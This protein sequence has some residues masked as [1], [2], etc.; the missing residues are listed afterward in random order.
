M[1]RVL[2]KFL[3]IW[4]LKY[5]CPSS[6]Y[7]KP[8]LLGQEG[9]DVDS[10]WARL[11]LSRQCPR[12]DHDITRVPPSVKRSPIL[13]YL[14]LSLFYI[15]RPTTNTLEHL[16]HHRNRPRSSTKSCFIL[17]HEYESFK[18]YTFNSIQIVAQPPTL[19]STGLGNLH[20]QI[21][22]LTCNCGT[23]AWDSEKRTQNSE[24]H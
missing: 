19:T 3:K 1:G 8:F 20:C 15:Q 13:S 11:F 21:K 16:G 9:S 6:W 14:W 4:Y 10:E 18:V 24:V 22:Q 23:V 12:L 5:L 7:A 17:D 2:L